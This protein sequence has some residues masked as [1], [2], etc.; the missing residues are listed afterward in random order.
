MT[1]M[2]LTMTRSIDTEISDEDLA[3]DNIAEIVKFEN[4]VGKR[5]IETIAG[6][7]DPKLGEFTAS[8]EERDASATELITFTP[9]TGLNTNTALT[10]QMLMVSLVALVILAIG[11]I[12]IKKTVLKK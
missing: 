11:I 10:I 12:V 5:D 8:L 4:T 3:Y 7:A 2:K 1:E 6:N 9:P